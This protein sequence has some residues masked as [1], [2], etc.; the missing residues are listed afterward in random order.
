MKIKADPDAQLST[1]KIKVNNGRV[2]I[3]VYLHKQ[4]DA[5]LSKLKALGF[6]KLARANSVNLLVGTIEASKLEELALIKTV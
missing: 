1:G 4:S 2:E 5:T 3:K 6:V